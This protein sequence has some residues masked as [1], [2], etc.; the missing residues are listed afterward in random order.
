ML[1]ITEITEE[2]ERSK[3]CEDREKCIHREKCFLKD[4]T[5]SQLIE[6][7]KLLA[8]IKNFY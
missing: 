3:D 8:M 6:L 1:K 5:E 2:K 4:L 7:G